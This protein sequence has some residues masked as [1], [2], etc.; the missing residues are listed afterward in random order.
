PPK[1]IDLYEQAES[2][3]RAGHRG[4][5]RLLLRELVRTSPGAVADQALYELALL[6]ERDGDVTE[7]RARVDELLAHDGAAALRAPAR[8]LRCRLDA[9]AHAYRRA[10][11]CLQ[12]FRSEFPA[13]PHDA[14]A[15]AALASFA[16]AD[17]DCPTARRL[18]AE[19][20]ARHRHG[21]FARE[22]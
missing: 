21:V 7:A 18:L 12:A 3:L 15:L 22:A 13:S 1:P 14:E 19:Y 9:D 4:E 8:Y 6:A 17:G 5:A 20:L 2:A 16:Q 11:V 10:A